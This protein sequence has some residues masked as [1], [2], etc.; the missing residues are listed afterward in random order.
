M[1]H[2][3][4]VFQSSIRRSEG[5]QGQWLSSKVMVIKIKTTIKNE[6]RSKGHKVKFKDKVRRSKLIYKVNYH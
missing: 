4:F 6:V 5:R 2:E 1:K 3:A